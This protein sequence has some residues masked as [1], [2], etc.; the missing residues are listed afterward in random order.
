MPNSNKPFLLKSDIEAAQKV[1]RS[2]AEAARFLGVTYTTYKKYA[3][4]YGIHEGFKNQAGVGISKG[5]YASSMLSR[6][7][8]IEGRYTNIK[9][10]RLRRALIKELVLDERCSLCGYKEARLTDKRVPLLLDFLDNDKTNRKVENL[11]L[12]CYNCYYNNVG[13]ILKG[14]G[15]TEVG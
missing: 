13:D 11:R 3:K 7:G 5:Y 12:L 15:K 1:C 10:P 4:M 6:K 14:P 8:L 2:A 9:I